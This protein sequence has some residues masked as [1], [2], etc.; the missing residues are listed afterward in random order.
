[1]LVGKNGSHLKS[2]ETFN[3]TVAVLQELLFQLVCKIDA[4]SL[5]AF[6][7]GAFVVD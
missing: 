6:Q 4:I 3:K 5:M 1:M 7:P 2:I